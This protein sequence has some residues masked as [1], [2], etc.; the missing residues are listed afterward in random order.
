M[1]PCVNVISVKTDCDSPITCRLTW[2]AHANTP[3]PRKSHVA[4]CSFWSRFK[5]LHNSCGAKCLSNAQNTQS[6]LW[7]M[8]GKQE[9]TLSFLLWKAVR[10]CLIKTVIAAAMGLF[11]SYW[12]V[13][14]SFFFFAS[15][16]KKVSSLFDSAWGLDMLSAVL[17]YRLGEGEEFTA[18]LTGSVSAACGGADGS[19]S[20]HWASVLV[21]EIQIL[22]ELMDETV[23][24]WFVDPPVSGESL[25]LMDLLLKVEW[26][27]Q[28]LLRWDVNT[29]WTQQGVRAL[30]HVRLGQQCLAHVHNQTCDLWGRKMSVSCGIWYLLWINTSGNLSFVGL[31][32]DFV[33]PP[34]HTHKYTC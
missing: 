16:W 26:E 28:H 27:C 34:T 17:Q 9:K 20:V 14:A 6:N 23:S 24:L 33:P 5:P 12:S 30:A 3:W 29:R 19:D 1:I 10:L 8:K 2:S 18:C 13:L 15:P 21:P 25:P 32:W 4:H 22:V 7:R 31:L 11:I